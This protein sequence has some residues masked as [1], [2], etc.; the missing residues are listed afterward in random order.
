LR[1]QLGDL[2]SYGLVPFPPPASKS[3]R[4]DAK[5]IGDLLQAT[6]ADPIGA[7]LVFL[8]LLEGDAQGWPLPFG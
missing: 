6:A 4:R 7:I 3:G 8:N 5:G 2:A 1:Q